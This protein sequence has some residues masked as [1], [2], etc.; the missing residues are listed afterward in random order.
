MSR[1]PYNA[2]GGC[3]GTWNLHQC[4]LGNVAHYHRILDTFRYYQL[5]YILLPFEYFLNNV[6]TL[7]FQTIME[8]ISNSHNNFYFSGASSKWAYSAK[9]DQIACFP[10]VFPHLHVLSMSTK[11]YLNTSASRLWS[12]C[13]SRILS[14]FT[15]ISEVAILTVTWKV[16]FKEMRS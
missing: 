1:V 8:T 14:F 9:L 7:K 13:L 3:P 4:I 10:S 11:C 5:L 2:G 12:V 6:Y 16:C 15:W